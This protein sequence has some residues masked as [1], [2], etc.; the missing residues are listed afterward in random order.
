M[1]GHDKNHSKD[2][3]DSS[4]T[5]RGFNASVGPI[6]GG[7]YQTW[8]TPNQV[9]D[10]AKEADAVDRQARAF[11]EIAG[12]LKKWEEPVAQSF[13]ELR[14]PAKAFLTGLGHAAHEVGEVLH[15]FR[16]KRIS[17]SVEYPQLGAP[18]DE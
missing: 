4:V 9:H 7:G 10:R 15:E 6:G 12:T 16:E 13:R 8:E 2:K 14:E 18:D 17:S 3:E 1:R 11:E 5:G